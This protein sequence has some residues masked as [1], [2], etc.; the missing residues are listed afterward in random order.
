MRYREC[1]LFFHVFHGCGR[2]LELD[3]DLGSELFKLL[4]H[5]HG[6][7][8]TG[9]SSQR[10]Q[11][12]EGCPILLG[13]FGHRFLLLSQGFHGISAGIMQVSPF[14]SVRQWKD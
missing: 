10:N 12:V 11:I 4:S 1:K 8:S 6:F 2:R 7:D 3:Q 9:L 5:L 13:E 14:M